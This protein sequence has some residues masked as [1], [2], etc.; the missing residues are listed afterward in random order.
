MPK[1]FYTEHDIE[2]LARQGITRLELSD[3]VVLT[4]LAYEKAKK[5]GFQ[6]GKADLSNPAAPVRPYIS[7]LAKN[8]LSAERRPSP[9]PAPEKPP[10]ISAAP[11]SPAAPPAACAFCAGR[12]GIDLDALRDRVKKAALAKMGSQLDPA[13]LDTVIER[14]INNIG[15]KQA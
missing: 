10:V 11:P 5:L 13:L 2:D 14:V 8:G 4:E 12:Q 9:L 1:Q 7:Q 3:D 15:L 6:L